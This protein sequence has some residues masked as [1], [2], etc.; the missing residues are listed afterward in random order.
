M[1]AGGHQ[2]E[3]LAVVE[4][5]QRVTGVRPDAVDVPLALKDQ[6]VVCNPIF[7]DLVLY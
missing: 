7:V 3:A 4:V 5:V 2:D 1:P 6:D